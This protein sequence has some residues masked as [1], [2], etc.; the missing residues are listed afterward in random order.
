MTS[1]WYL[2]GY[3]FEFTKYVSD[4]VLDMINAVDHDKPLLFI[5]AIRF[6]KSS[7]LLLSSIE[8]SWFMPTYEA[9]WLETTAI[10]IK[11]DRNQFHWLFFH[12]SLQI[13]INLVKLH[14]KR[15]SVKY[16]AMLLYK[17][18]LGWMFK[19][20]LSKTQIKNSAWVSKNLNKSWEVFEK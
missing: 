12:W 2:L 20:T 11:G 10:T 19:Q 14:I 18:Y 3:M 4:T 15:F 13:A 9:C 5:K 6:G 16:L 8:W 1:L 17:I 7:C